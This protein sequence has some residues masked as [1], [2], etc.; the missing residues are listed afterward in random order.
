MKMRKWKSKMP[1][2][3]WDAFGFIFVMGVAALL[4]LFFGK[5]SL[6]FFEKIIQFFG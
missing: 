3:F 5:I 2:G 6:F 4:C 1:R